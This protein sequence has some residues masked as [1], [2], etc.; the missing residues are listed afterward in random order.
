MLKEGG[1]LYL[2]TDS[3]PLWKVG[4]KAVRPAFKNKYG[5][6]SNKG[7][8]VAFFTDLLTS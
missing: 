5:Y 7:T 6:V 2:D 4:N 1:I 8:T 3:G